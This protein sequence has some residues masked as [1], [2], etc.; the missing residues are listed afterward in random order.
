MEKVFVRIAGFHVGIDTHL[1]NFVG[2]GF[3][4]PFVD[5]FEILRYM[6][7]PEIHIN[8]MRAFVWVLTNGV[9]DEMEFIVIQ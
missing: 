3:S 2:N 5:L 7:D 9:F 4:N 6:V 8:E 1:S